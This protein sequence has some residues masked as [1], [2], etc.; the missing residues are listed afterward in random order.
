M[1]YECSPYR[2][3]EWAVGWGRVLEAAR[4]FDPHVITS[5]SN[6]AALTRARDEGLLPPNVHFYTPPPD[7]KLRRL[8]RKPALFA[9]NYTAYHHWQRLAFTLARDLHAEHHFALVHQ[10]NVATFRE[11]GYTWQLGIPYIWGPVGG[12]QN[13]PA[14][15]LPMLPPIEAAKEALRGLSNWLSLRLKPR[16]RRAA[17]AAGLIIAAN[18]TNQ[19]DYAR[20]F[21]RPPD[22]PIA[23]LLE[24]GLH[25]V[26]EPDRTRFLTRAGRF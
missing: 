10:V 15:F 16:V 12:T 9:Y 19:R 6:F 22:K 3:S 20:V 2:G 5:E 18:S 8:E 14:R 25:T 4:A 26:E 13:F 24:T 7:A 11:P 17:R 21:K 23:L 1:A